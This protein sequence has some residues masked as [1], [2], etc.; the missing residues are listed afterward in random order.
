MR[1]VL[2][3]MSEGLQGTGGRRLADCGLDS[4]RVRGGQGDGS[5]D[6]VFALQTSQPDSPEPKQNS[7]VW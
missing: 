7:P 4:T 5:G 6:K 1:G 3:M 2:Q